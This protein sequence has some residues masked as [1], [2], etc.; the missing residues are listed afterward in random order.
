VFRPHTSGM[1][2]SAQHAIRTGSTPTAKTD[3]AQD[4]CWTS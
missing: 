4:G 1:L 2:T 3:L